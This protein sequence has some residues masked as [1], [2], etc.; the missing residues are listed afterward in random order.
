MLN[1]LYPYTQSLL[2]KPPNKQHKR[3]KENSEVLQAKGT[4]RDSQKKIIK[5]KREREVERAK[6]SG[7]TEPRIKNIS[8]DLISFPR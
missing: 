3:G 5:E 6:I 2:K 1:T 4:I 8:G 7:L